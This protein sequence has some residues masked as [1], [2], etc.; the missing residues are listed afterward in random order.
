MR[1]L[2][3]GQWLPLSLIHSED[4][5]GYPHTGLNIGPLSD[6]IDWK[7]LCPKLKA[8]LLEGAVKTSDTSYQTSPFRCAV[9]ADYIEEYPD[10]VS[11]CRQWGDR[12]LPP[13]TEFLALVL[14][15]VVE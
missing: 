11:V 13:T 6:G 2:L 7:V 15:S 9:A 3:E 14:R 4:W 10:S 8:L 5:D 12:T 1:V